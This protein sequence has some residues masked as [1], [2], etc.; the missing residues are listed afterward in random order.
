M[1][2]TLRR[3]TRGNRPV[4]RQLQDLENV[5]GRSPVFYGWREVSA[6]TTIVDSDSMLLVDTT[7]GSVTITLP[8]ASLNAGRRFGVK[9]KVAGNTL[10]LSSADNIDGAGTAAVTT[11]YAV[12]LVQSDGVTW[13]RLI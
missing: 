11:Q 1:S 4:D 8:A 3:W 2:V 13:W 7:A 6:A 12:I 10:T 9:K 5:L